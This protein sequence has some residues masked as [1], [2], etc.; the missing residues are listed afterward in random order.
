M[1]GAYYGKSIV[2]NTS[3][4]TF[5]LRKIRRAPLFHSLI[6]LAS[7]SSH[8]SAVEQSQWRQEEIVA[9]VGYLLP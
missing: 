3:G 6:A 2:N 4:C 1:I 5:L 8:C 9:S 7:F